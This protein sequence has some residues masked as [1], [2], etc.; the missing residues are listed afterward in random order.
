MVFTARQMTG[1]YGVVRVEFAD[2]G[3]GIVVDTSMPLVHAASS[4]DAFAS[5][6]PGYVIGFAAR[7]GG[8][9]DVD[10]AVRVGAVV[11][12]SIPV[13]ANFPA[14]ANMQHVYPVPIF[15]EAAQ[16][17]RIVY[18]AVSGTADVSVSLFLALNF[19]D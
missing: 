6:W 11:G 16:F 4:G 15:F 10:I 17:I 7:G 14:T 8:S 19:E 5:P 9:L 2:T 18:T 13:A 3:A 12:D 1:G